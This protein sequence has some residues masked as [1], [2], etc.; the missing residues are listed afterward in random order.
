MRKMSFLSARKRNYQQCFGSLPGKE[1]LADMAAFCFAGGDCFI[2][3]D[4]DRTM[5][6]IGRRQVYLRIAHHLHQTP[7]QL[8]ALYDAL[9][10]AR[11]AA[12][13]VDDSR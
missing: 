13:E 7:E 11:M 10:A 5:I 8:F 6:A 2:P 1:V 12:G 3:G 9:T 4:H